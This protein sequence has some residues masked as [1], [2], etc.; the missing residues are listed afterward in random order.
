MTLNRDAKNI[1]TG[2]T[3]TLMKEIDSSMLVEGRA[4]AS[5]L[6]NGGAELIKGAVIQI[7]MGGR[8]RIGFTPKPLTASQTKIAE[9]VAQEI[10]ASRYGELYSA[11]LSAALF[12]GWGALAAR[13]W[14]LGRDIANHVINDLF[15]EDGEPY[16]LRAFAYIGE[17]RYRE[18]EEDL[19]RALTL[20]PTLS[21][22][23][24][25]LELL[26]EKNNASA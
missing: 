10:A 18:A 5:D 11:A 15:V 7:L 1:V 3:V 21:G 13:Q 14:G 26:R 17:E 19:D 22:A 24:E 6:Q 23:H 25:M 2:F 12:H 16:R 9:D 20:R 4:D 8:A